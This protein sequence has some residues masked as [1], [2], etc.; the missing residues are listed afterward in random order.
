MNAVHYLDLLGKRGNGDKLWKFKSNVSTARLSTI[1]ALKHVTMNRKSFFI[2]LKLFLHTH[3]EASL[4]QH[5]V[6]G[7]GNICCVKV[8]VVRIFVPA[9]TLLH[10]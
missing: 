5:I 6:D 2:K 7:L 3:H 4:A 1:Q 9:V 10:S 8:V